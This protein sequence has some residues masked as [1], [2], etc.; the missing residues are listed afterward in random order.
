M[1][2]AVN[3]DQTVPENDSEDLDLDQTSVDTGQIAENDKYCRP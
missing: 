2:N 3:T 1:A